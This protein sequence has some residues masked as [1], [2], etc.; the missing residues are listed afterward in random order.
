MSSFL[1][2]VD[3]AC[4]ELSKSLGRDLHSDEIERVED[5][6]FIAWLDARKFDELI[7]YAH[8]EF[9]LQDGEAFC[10][11]LSTALC[12]IKDTTRFERLY[13]GLIRSREAAFWRLDP[14][15][16]QAHIGAMKESAMRLASAMQSLAG[17]YHCYWT[18]NDEDGKRRVQDAML[19]LQ[20]RDK[21]VQPNK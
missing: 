17:L 8:E 7:D 5:E 16:Q 15:A 4:D 9:E 19:G 10:T 3:D 21:P 14:Q 20:R 13:H 11:S 2:A 6:T 18:I 1:S 12:K